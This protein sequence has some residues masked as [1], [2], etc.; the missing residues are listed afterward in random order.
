MTAAAAAEIEMIREISAIAEETAVTARPD[1]PLDGIA[2]LDAIR[3]DP[4]ASMAMTSTA[5]RDVT[6]IAATAGAVTETRMT[7]KT[8][9]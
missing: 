6:A 9:L 4:M 3:P 7:L 2:V 1:D 8:T 5:G